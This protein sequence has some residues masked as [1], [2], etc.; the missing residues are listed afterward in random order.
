MVNLGYKNTKTDMKRNLNR[1]AG[2]LLCLAACLSCDKTEEPLSVKTSTIS[3]EKAFGLADLFPELSKSPSIQYDDEIGYNILLHEVEYTQHWT[4]DPVFMP[5][6]TFSFDAKALRAEDEGWYAKVVSDNVLSDLH[7][8][9]MATDM[10]GG[11]CPSAVKLHIELGENVPYRKVTLEDLSVRFPTWFRA[12]LDG[13]EDGRIP[14]L[15]VTSEGVDL[16]IRFSS[17]RTDAQKDAEGNFYYP[18]ETTFEARVTASPEDAVGPVSDTPSELE[19]HCTIEFGQINFTYCDL[20][21]PGISF[22]EMT[23]ECNPVELPSFLCGKESDITLC[24]PRFIFDNLDDFPFTGSHYEIALLSGERKVAFSASGNTNFLF[25]ANGEGYYQEYNHCENV[26]AMGTLFH[27]PFSEGKLAA[28]IFLQAAVDEDGEGRF[29][30]G[31]EYNMRAK[32]QLMVPLAFTGNLD[33]EPVSTPALRLEGGIYGAPGNSNH[34]IE[35]K[36]G[37][38]LPVDCKI[39]P[40]FTMDGEEPEFLDDFILDAQHREVVF[41]HTFHP[42]ND[43]WEATLYY[44]VTPLRGYGEYLMKSDSQRLIIGD[45][46]LTANVR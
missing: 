43:Q 42:I 45:T 40:V 7:L 18:V 24:K 30:P 39:T 1:I 6:Q 27:G 14:K 26:E 5:A 21:F 12:E 22:L 10:N 38:T 16:P 36:V 34:K 29:V 2:A 25:T 20:C 31:K 13:A 32:Y 46:V 28:S 44:L 19:F 15:E 17:I 23:F 33:A 41:S 35:Q 9:E 4:C 11:G 8:P 37:S 3:F